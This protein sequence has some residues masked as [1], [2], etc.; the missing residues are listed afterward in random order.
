MSGWWFWLLRVSR[1]L[2]VRASLYGFLAVVA[3]LVAALFAPMVPHEL[4]ERLGG[5]AVENIL[6]ALASSLLAVSTFSV[7]AVVVAYT[8]VS[9]QVTPR[10]AT[11]I[12]TDG[13][14][15]RALATFVGAFLFAV[16]ALVALGADYYGPGGRTILFMAT[17][18][19]VAIVATTLLGWIDRLVRLAQYGHLL[20]QI[21]DAT[22][23]AMQTR[24]KNPFLGGHELKTPSKFG[25]VLPA[26][27]A[28]YIANIDPA[29][30][31]KFAEGLD[32]TVEVLANP[33][34]FMCKYQPLVRI[35]ERDTLSDDERDQLCAA[36]SFSQS[37]TFEQD[38][39]YGLEV[40]TEVAAR[41]LSPGVNDPGTAV[42]V[43]DACYR[44]LLEWGEDSECARHE[45]KYPRI[46]SVALDGCEMLHVSLG[47]IAR[48][49]AG[50]V[51]VASRIQRVLTS[52]A[53]IGFGQCARDAAAVALER[54][55]A[56]LRLEADIERVRAAPLSAS[57]APHP[58]AL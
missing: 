42:L 17:L 23:S 56:A 32:C 6:G 29:R 46:K 34:A 55:S 44:L 39:R 45:V 19:M 13:A 21:E 36:Y 48:Y 37:R 16:V 4:S 49:G 52:L 54:S 22:R 7:S 40:L 31:S 27:C 10:A 43:V 24:R 38:P 11:F 20:A 53:H 18:V 28:G 26:P 15:Q 35:P 25:A 41:A 9:A 57:A 2:I 8:A 33:G 47:E 51:L 1:R 50:D 12:T 30:L 3:A 58:D 14:T 5:E